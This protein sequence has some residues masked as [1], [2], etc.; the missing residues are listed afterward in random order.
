V[1][2]QLQARLDHLQ[3]LARQ[4]LSGT[5]EIDR[6]AGELNAVL[7]R[8]QRRGPDALAGR[9]Q[10]QRQLP[11]VE[12][13]AHLAAEPS[14]KVAEVALF[15]AVHVFAHAAGEHGRDRS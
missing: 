11:G 8:A 4:E 3:V 7:R 2:F 14:S 5:G 6:V 1:V 10:L 13:V 15:T 12:P 9:Q